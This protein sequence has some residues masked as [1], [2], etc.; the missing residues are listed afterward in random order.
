MSSRRELLTQVSPG[1]ERDFTAETVGEEQVNLPLN[2]L[3]DVRQPV[4]C[5][6]FSSTCV[7][8]GLVT[9]L[10]YCEAKRGF[11]T[12]NYSRG[13]IYA[14]R[15]D[16]D[17]NVSGMYLRK[18]LKIMQKEGTY[19][20]YSFRWGQSSLSRTLEKFESIGENL[21]EEA[22]LLSPM[23]S[24]YR[25]NSFA[26]LKRAIYNN[27][28]AVISLKVPKNYL[29]CTRVEAD[30]RH[31]NSNH[32]VAV[33]GWEG[34]YLIC[35]DGYSPLRGEK[36]LFYVHKDYAINEMW[37]IKL[38]G[39]ERGWNIVP[40]FKEKYLGYVT[41]LLEWALGGLIFNIKR[42]FTK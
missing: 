36:G 3:P 40:T 23:F 13:F 41:Y 16:E 32:C 24:Y 5:Q 20:Y 7:A 25:L 33:I 37:S 34:D 26:E 27:G 21:E 30:T 39:K 31:K 1:D 6:W 28:A 14:N 17:M 8:H 18:A 19:S 15:N 42:L 29:F 4:M 10:Q 2:Y 38:T 35:Q 22:S 12:N 11:P 9:M